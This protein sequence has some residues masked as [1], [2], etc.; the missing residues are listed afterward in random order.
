LYAIDVTYASSRR[1]ISTNPKVEYENTALFSP[2]FYQL[3]LFFSNEGNPEW[4]HHRFER[5]GGNDGC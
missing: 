4:L 3:N 5:W 2:S 1:Q